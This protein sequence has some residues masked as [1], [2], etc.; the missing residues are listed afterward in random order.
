MNERIQ[1]LCAY[2]DASKSVYHAQDLL[3][4]ELEKAGYARL[5][6]ADSWDLVPGGKYFVTRGGTAVLAFRIPQGSPAGFLMSASHSDRPTFKVKENAELAGTSHG[7][8]SSRPSSNPSC[9]QADHIPQEA[10][11]YENC[12]DR[13]NIQENHR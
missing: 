7:I 2:L 8:P 5:S 6:E 3:V 13:S 9:L 10:N 11:S 12:S 1:A 4:K